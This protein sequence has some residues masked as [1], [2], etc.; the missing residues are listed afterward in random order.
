[1]GRRVYA[2]LPEIVGDVPP[3]VDHTLPT[4]CWLDGTE[5]VTDD[6][7]TDADDD[8]HFVFGVECS[9]SFTALHDN[10]DC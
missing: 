7:A 1:M 8:E 6:A 9:N 2:I 10:D 4:L 5:T 3:P